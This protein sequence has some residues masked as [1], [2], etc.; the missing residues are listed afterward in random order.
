MQTYILKTVFGRKKGSTE[1]RLQ[2]WLY[3]YANKLASIRDIRESIQK[4]ASVV[5]QE[6]PGPEMLQK[7][8]DAEL[9]ISEEIKTI[10]NSNCRFAYKFQALPMNPTV[11]QKKK[12]KNGGQDGAGQ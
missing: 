3:L 10:D 2:D 4:L 9:I 12:S 7:I 1:G 8:L 5:V 6:N 11:G